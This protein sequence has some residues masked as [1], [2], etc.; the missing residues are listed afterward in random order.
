[1]FDWSLSK[2]PL[3]KLTERMLF[4]ID[5]RSSASNWPAASRTAPG[6]DCDAC[7][8]RRARAVKSIG[9]A[10][11]VVTSDH[12]QLGTQR[13]G[14]LERF[15]DRDQVAGRGADAIDGLH[16]L[17]KRD[18]RIEQEHVAVLFVHLEVRTLHDFR[19]AAAEGL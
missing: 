8:R 5:C 15:Q 13:A 4:S 11:R 7:P 6:D 9:A 2:S 18:A 1:M 17:I 16:D 14:F 3:P 12:D 10:A 19:R